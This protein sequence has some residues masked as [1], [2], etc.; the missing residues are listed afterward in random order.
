MFTKTLAIGAATAAIACSITTTIAAP[1]NLANPALPVQAIEIVEIPRLDFGAIDAEDLRRQADGDPY[2]Y[3]IPHEVSVTPATAGT[4]ER[5]DDTTLMWRL[6]VMSSDATSINLAFERFELPATGL[7]SVSTTDGNVFIRPF[8]ADDNN[9]DRQLWTPPIPGDDILVEI[10]VD[11]RDRDFVEQSMALTRINVGYRGFYDLASPNRS[12]SCNYDVACAEADEWR[13]E[14]PCVAAISTG[15]SLFCT[16]FMVNNVRQD[17]TPLFMTA[18]HCGVGSGNA[19]SLVAFWNFE[20]DFDAPL[21]CPGNSSE[22]GTLDQFSTGASFRAEGSA[23]DFTIVEF[24]T[25][26]DDTWEVAYCGWDARDQATDCSVAIHHPSVDA[27]RWSIDYDPSAI[28]TY[29]GDPGDDHLTI[30]DWDLGTTEPG[31]SGSPMFDCV[32]HRVVGQLHGGYAACGNDDEDWYGRIGYSWDA[33]LDAVLDPDGT[34]TLFVD[35][36][37]KGLSIDPAVDVLHYGEVGGPFTEDTIVYTLS[38]NTPDAVQYRVSQFGNYALHVNGTTFP[39]SGTLAAEGGTID[40][41]VSLAPATTSLPAGNYANTLLFEDLTNGSERE[42][43]H[44]LEVGISNFSTNPEHG[45]VA[46]GPLGGPF[47]STQNYVVTSLRPT[48]A[49]IEITSDVDWISINGGAS[50]SITLLNEGDDAIVTI[51]FSDAANDLP[52]GIVE[53]TVTFNNYEGDG[54]DT[55]RTVVLDVGRF[56]YTAYDTPIPITDNATITSDIEVGDAYCIGDVDV[57]MDISHTYIGDLIIDLTSPEGTTVRLHDRSGGGDDDILATYDDDGD[58]TLPDGPG[59]LSDFDGELVA[60]TWTLTLSDN[61]GADTGSLNAWTLKIAS[62]GETCPPVAYDQSVF[63]DV[64]A[65]IDIVLDGA[66]PE[67][68]S[69]SFTVTSLPSDGTLSHSTLG[70]LTSAP[71]TLPF[72][73]DTVT[74]AP[75]AG[76]LG[77]DGFGF[78]VN[79]GIDSN[80]AYVS[81]QVGAVPNPDDCAQAAPI[82]NGIWDFDTSSATTDG[83]A[84]GECQFDGQTYHDIWYSY[85]ACGDGNLLVS[86]C[87]DLGGGADYDTDLVVYEGSDCGSLA[88]LGCNDDDPDNA[89]GSF[90]GGYESTLNIAV[91]DG[92]EYRIRVGGWNEGNQ[93]TGLL[94]IDGPVGDCDEPCIGDYTEDGLVNVNDLLYVISNWNAPFN[95]D[96]LLLV[97]ANWNSNCP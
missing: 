66:S 7:L 68:G 69:L 48:D 67:G 41:T 6:R 77:S 61:A 34:G 83:S 20:D 8:T 52:N 5:L 1:G 27:K 43:I 11:E 85:I 14:I 72:F 56:T 59:T 37:G 33:G 88:L 28:T 3:A 93:G 73:S 36:L 21:D 49:L 90:D 53:G 81:I 46:G 13:D 16:G 76:Y 30:Y 96:D 89:C 39:A 92:T 22:T 58:G 94:V 9:I 10:Q 35:T 87:G 38:N 80:E 12:G 71:V 63:T 75:D 42:L 60:G 18:Y 50:D 17:G 78:R 57:E 74:Y 97:I 86:T 95:V 84:H 70:E 19:S 62:T 44:S 32:T 55:T 2:R 4:W 29:Y 45:L 26:P 82:G 91:T 65:D 15:G 23:S 25:A 31:S 24:N 51:G 79:D 47:P 40:V 64:D 54:G